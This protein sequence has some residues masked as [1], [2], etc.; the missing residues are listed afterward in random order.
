MSVLRTHAAAAILGVSPNTLRSWERRFG[1]PMPRRTAGGHRQFDLAEIEALRQAFEE[2][3]NVSSAISIARERGSGPSSPT[4]LRSALRRFDELD[5][6]RILEESLAVR[7]VERS[8]EEVLLPAIDTLRPADGESPSAEL[9]FALRWA[10]GWLAAAKRVAPGATRPE[11][12]LVFDASGPCDIDSLHA[13]ALE[14][15]LRRAGIRTLLLTAELDASRLAHVLQ[16]LS[17]RLVVLTGR[18]AWLDA[19]SRIAYQTRGAVELVEVLDFRA[20]L[21]ENG[22]SSVARL[23]MSAVGARDLL[24]ARLN[25]GPPVAQPRGPHGL[26]QVS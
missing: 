10:T 12:I 7:S 13:Q 4:R 25:A 1:Y 18:R 14:L 24:L 9:G 15:F 16:A 8:V 3:H 5:A 19:V 21:G 2:T 11:G 17:P 20:A 23:G 6:D 26:A 22:H